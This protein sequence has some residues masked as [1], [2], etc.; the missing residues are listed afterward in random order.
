MYKPSLNRKEWKLKMKYCM[1]C[2]NLL[3]IG[4]K[5]TYFLWR[6]AF[7]SGSLNN[8]KKTKLFTK[9]LCITMI[10]WLKNSQWKILKIKMLQLIIVGHAWLS[11]V[12]LMKVKLNKEFKR[13]LDRTWWMMMKCNS[14]SRNS[15][16]RMFF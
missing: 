7:L 13:L 1:F 11:F 2:M 16:L 8:R 5:N 9:L 6:E 15:F 4:M 10:F 14:S 12:V 3:S